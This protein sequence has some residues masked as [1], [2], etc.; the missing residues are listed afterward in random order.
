MPEHETSRTLV[1]SLPELW[2]E[3]SDAPSLG[4]HLGAFGEIR[5]TKLEPETAV[6]W[7]GDDIR[8]TV[9]LESSGWG[10]RVTLT[11]AG[12]PRAVAAQ[13]AV[14]LEPVVATADA[15]NAAAEAAEAAPPAPAGFWARLK[16]RWSRRPAP[17]HPVV[18]QVAPAP[19]PVTAEAEPEA[20]AVAP[21]PAADAQDELAVLTHA[22]D[23]LGKA[24][25]R[26]YSRD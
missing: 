20:E 19:P 11:A 18:E 14:V 22:L 1:K 10:T 4:R 3:C 2:A 15:V 13:P 12:E 26:P 6:A 7:E 17:P 25:H 16:A 23:S 8:G 5:I 9:T 24:H 21:P